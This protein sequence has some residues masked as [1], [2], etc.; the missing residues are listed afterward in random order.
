M[1]FLSLFVRF[2]LFNIFFGKFFPNSFI[3][4]I[5]KIYWSMNKC[6]KNFYFFSPFFLLPTC[7][8]VAGSFIFSHSFIKVFTHKQLHTNYTKSLIPFLKVIYKNDY[9]LKIVLD[10]KKNIQFIIQCIILLCWL[11]LKYSSIKVHFSD[12]TAKGKT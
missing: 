7:L 12:V 10:V 1:Y 4:T 9:F 8:H 5:Y 11:I 2:L 6:K 3:L